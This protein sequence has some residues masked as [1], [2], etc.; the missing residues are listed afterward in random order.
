MTQTP[1][2]EQIARL[3]YERGRKT[4][5]MGDDVETWD[6]AT[7]CWKQA[8]Y[9]DADAILALPAL[10]ALLHR[11]SQGAAT[12]HGLTEDALTVVRQA[13]NILFNME[14]EAG[15]GSKLEPRE[16]ECCREVRERL[17]RLTGTQ[18]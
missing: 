4:L 14:Q 3:I 16:R 17:D 5:R 9:D 12:A 13:S 10:K 15:P 1:T 2:R 6:T 8:C 18:Q 7:P 11:P